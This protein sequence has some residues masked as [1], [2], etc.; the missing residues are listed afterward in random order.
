[1]KSLGVVM[2]AMNE[3]EFIADSLAA[4]LP[5]VDEAIVIDQNS[6]DRTREIATKMGAAVILAPGNFSTMGERWYRDLAV[7]VCS[8]DWM[9]PLDADEVFSDGWA[10]AVR[11]HLSDAIGAISIP[12]YHL[13]A[14]YEY[15]SLASPLRRHAFVRRHSLLSGCPPMVGPFAH[16]HYHESYEPKAVKELDSCAIFHLGY[17]RADMAKRWE[18]IILRGDFNYTEQ[19][20]RENIEMLRENPLNGFPKVVPLNIPANEYPSVLRPRVG[21]T[22]AIDYDADE[23]KIRGRVRIS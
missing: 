16:S 11:P 5:F 17:V 22:Y 3:E 7:K 9:M 10:D 20:Q 12:F 2:L 1:M 18:S 15:H 14:S 4:V 21:R 19:E 6:R 23:M 8:C 13:M